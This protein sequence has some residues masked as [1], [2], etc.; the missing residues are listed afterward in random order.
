[1]AASKKTNEISRPVGAPAVS[2]EER[3]DQLIAMAFDRI[4]Q[5]M[6]EGTASSA[7]L[8]YL[9]KLGS[10]KEQ[11]ERRNLEMEIALKEARKEQLGSV[12]QQNALYEKALRAFSKYQG[13]EDDS[14][15]A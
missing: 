12:E 13:V 9:A 5:R 15:V 6:I 1:M 8:V 2:A 3:E 10:E 7:E 4:E 11:L 14:D